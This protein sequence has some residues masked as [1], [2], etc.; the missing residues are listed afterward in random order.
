MATTVDYDPFAKKDSAQT[1][2][3]VVEH[4][5]FKGQQSKEHKPTTLERGKEVLKETGIGG[6]AG[7]F[8]PELLQGAGF[9]SLA[10]PITA[11]AAPFLSAAGTALRAARVPSMIAGAVGGMA[12]ETGGQ[13]LEAK[14]YPKTAEAARLGL[15]VLAPEAG[16]MVTTP[17]GKAITSI[18][19]AVPGMKTVKTVGQLLGEKGVPE[20]SLTKEQRA[21]IEKKI[22]DIRG[23]QPSLEAQKEVFNFLEKSAKDIIGQAEQK[24]FKSQ[25]EFNIWSDQTKSQA[26]QEAQKIIGEARQRVVSNNSRI[27]QGDISARQMTDIENNAM[28]QRA[29]QQATQIRNQATQKIEQAKR[30]M[31]KVEQKVEPLSGQVQAAQAKIGQPMLPTDVGTKLR[32]KIMPEFQRLVETRKTEADKAFEGFM[33]NA[34]M[35]EQGGNK[36]QNTKAYKDAI[37]SIQ[38]ELIN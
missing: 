22:A 3:T 29:E 30:I 36:I 26:E 24:V 37:T 13:V 7:L 28:L 31:G 15:A 38:N 6:L 2:G 33:Q 32:D 4:D 20:A 23:G 16:R 11:P 8:A 21:F 17:I 1:G 19:S 9:L 10:T 35:K 18:F 5:P 34:L 27:S 14:G 25:S 12:G